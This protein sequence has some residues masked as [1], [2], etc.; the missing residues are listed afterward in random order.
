VIINGYDHER[1]NRYNVAPST[2]V[3][4]IRPGDGGPRVDKVKWGWAPFW[5]RGKRPDPINARV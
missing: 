1:I 5:A 4:I 3:E 2:K